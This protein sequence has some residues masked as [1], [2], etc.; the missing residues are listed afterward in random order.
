[1]I[2]YENVSC[3]ACARWWMRS[4]GGTLAGGMIGSD[5]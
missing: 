2:D 4:D 1:M 3:L 5:G